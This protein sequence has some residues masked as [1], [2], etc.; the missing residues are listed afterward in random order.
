MRALAERLPFHYA[1]LILGLAVL[2]NAVTTGS[3]FWVVAVYVPAVADDL[4]VGRTGVV[5]AFMAGNT[6]TAL[7]GP[8]TGRCIDLHGA[9]RGLWIGGLVVPLAL[10]LTAQSSTLWPLALGWALTSVPRAFVFG[11]SYNWLITR[12]FER[13]R[14]QA[15][16]VA[17]VGFGAGG[18]VVLP[19]LAAV[20]QRADWSTAMVVSAG[21]ILVFQTA[22]LLLLRDR[23]SALGLAPEGVVP[24]AAAVAA[25]DEGGFTAGAAVRSLSF[26]LIA[27]AL[28]LFFTGQGAIA[29]LAIDFFDSRDVANGAAIVA[30]GALLR[31]ILR[32]PLGLSLSR[33][34]RVFLLATVVAATQAIAILVLLAATSP[35][36]IVVYVLLWGVG[37]S[38]APML[39]PLLVTRAFGV[40]HFGAV[41]GAVAMVAFGGQMVG[42]VGGAAIFDATGSYTIPFA[43]YAAGLVGAMAL[44]TAS[45][46]SLRS[47]GHRAAA[48]RAGMAEPR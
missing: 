33:L 45:A 40:R 38:F 20:E 9:R 1:W 4:G 15:L 6:I 19:L 26:W 23:P 34:S 24:G 2:A 42:P 36:G 35:A 16:G 28:M 30:A 21:L 47:R 12:W 10:V 8:L 31:T 14:L 46:M 22:P 48:A 41:S 25:E 32:L 7:V 11:V 44:F 17:T 5:T 39:E 37:G 27:P 3:M 13:S 43:L 29:T 18:A